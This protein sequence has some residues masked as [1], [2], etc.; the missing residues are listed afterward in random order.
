ML[1][2]LT[3][4]F[5]DQVFKNLSDVDKILQIPPHVLDRT[6]GRLE[7]PLDPKKLELRV[8]RKAVRAK[9]GWHIDPVAGQPYSS[10]RGFLVKAGA[11][12]G[13]ID[14][15]SFYCFRRAMIDYINSPQFT[16]SDR[17]AAAG[18][19]EDS[20][21]QAGAYL[22]KNTRIDTASVLTGQKEVADAGGAVRGLR[23]FHGVPD[24]ISAQGRQEV[25]EDEELVE[26]VQELVPLRNAVLKEHDTLSAAREA[27][28]ESYTAYF[29]AY[30]A[31]ENLRWRLLRA[32][33]REETRDA[34][35]NHI[36]SVL[37]MAQTDDPDWEALL[38]QDDPDAAP[39]AGG[40]GSAQPDEAQ[41][42][43]DLALEGGDEALPPPK[44]VD[45]RAAELA[46]RASSL[47]PMLAASPNALQTLADAVF[48]RTGPHTLTSLI[49][50]MRSAG[51]ERAQD[52]RS[53]GVHFDKDRC[54]P[55]CR[56]DWEAILGDKMK[57]RKG[58]LG[59]KEEQEHV[60]ACIRKVLG[61]Q[62]RE[63]EEAVEDAQGARIPCP[64]GCKTDFANVIER[65]KHLSEQ[66]SRDTHCGIK[67]DDGTVCQHVFGT[68][69]T[70]HLETRHGFIATVSSVAPL[71]SIAHCIPCQ[72]WICGAGPVKQHA[73]GHATE[74]TDIL[75][76][77]LA[78][79]TG[80]QGGARLCP[81][82]LADDCLEPDDR[83][84][85][86]GSNLA[87][88]QHIA[89]HI[90]SLHLMG[91]EAPC[92]F[93]G[94][95]AEH[96]SPAALADHLI[97]THHIFIAGHVPGTFSRGTI[98]D[99]DLTKLLLNKATRKKLDKSLG[100]PLSSD[101][102]L[103]TMRVPEL[104]DLAQQ[105]GVTIVKPGG[106]R[107]KNRTQLLADIQAA[108]DAEEPTDRKKRQD[109]D[110]DLA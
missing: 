63:A 24:G 66:H 54:C 41:G 60:A 96:A 18:H 32:K 16:D 108:K 31:S 81:F 98:L 3:L 87:H 12:A 52:A 74:I 97:D 56:R 104:R 77:P 29:T 92:P 46:E 58:A 9:D 69:F 25:A 55:A 47:R 86:L 38:Q 103:E 85:A 102:E 105:L 59:L 99:G 79:A 36:D 30:R 106:G 40:S 17:R 34:V 93:T 35:S 33:K 50:L 22:S 14:K 23:V 26:L 49:A 73:D 107:H 100:P 45:R 57:S 95:D 43:D 15:V 68:D 61:R 53:P 83:L 109:A 20:H 75:A 67:H 37:A 101:E 2:L 65:G 42:D 39:Q 62:L 76:D 1:P 91:E 71:A 70:F 4:A 19:N 78:A 94:C 82:C 27:G 80:K 5:E 110:A 28:A 90:V 84:K 88:Q 13:Y 51:R 44:I 21:V 6:G 11:K 72:A 64:K 48:G 8:M 89:H 10:A 7:I